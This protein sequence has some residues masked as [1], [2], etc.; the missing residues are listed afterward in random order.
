[1]RISHWPLLVS[2]CMLAAM[3]GHT[4][5]AAEPAGER[6]GAVY[7]SDE[8]IDG[9]GLVGGQ[10]G[11]FAPYQAAQYVQEGY[12]GGFAPPPNGYFGPPAAPPNYWP[13]SSPFTQHRLEETYNDGNLWNYNTDDDFAVK[14]YFALDYLYGHGEKPGPHLVGNTNFANTQVFP[15]QPGLFPT[16]STAN[17]FSGPFHNGVMPR[18]GFE[19][20]D[21]SGIIVSGFYLVEHGDTFIE[22]AGTTGP[23]VSPLASIIVDGGPTLGGIALPFDT[24]FFMKN[25]Q[26]IL[27]ADADYYFAPFFTRN[28]FKMKMLFGA[29]YLRISEDMYIEGDD[30]GLGYTVQN[31]TGSGGGGGGAQQP[32]IG[33]F[34][35]VTAPYATTINTQVI[36]NL[37]GPMLGVRYDLGGDKFKIWGQSKV[38]LLAD[39]EQIT[40]TS[41]NVQQFKTALP[42]GVAPN[43]V[44]G[45]AANAPSVSSKVY[46]SATH[47]SPVFDTSVYV[48]FPFFQIVPYVNQ[49]SIFKTSNVRIGYN[50]VVVGEIA[51]PMNST[52]FALTNPGVQAGRTW[53]GYNT[54]NFAID[55]KW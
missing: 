16:P 11:G 54:V 5:L 41:S 4:S 46:Q 15:G 22:K 8:G 55:W 42:I 33:P 38:G 28:S 25:T 37:V 9:S 27:G 3:I 14:H 7:Q 34:L 35:Q 48:Q 19:N 26:S 29:K 10:A 17:T 49:L 52:Y 2:G 45:P 47:V 39:V 51:R 13:Q 1:M 32:I 21:G 30:S 18:F 23:G 40:V 20:P 53:F 6:S 24:R 50:Y 44:A 12:E 31:P 43:M 36:N